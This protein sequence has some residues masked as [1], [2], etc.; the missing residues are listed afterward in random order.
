VAATSGPKNVVIV[1]DTSGSMRERHR[2]ALAITAV[3]T[4]LET[5]TISDSAAVIGFSSTATPVRHRRHCYCYCFFCHA[6]APAPAP[7]IF[8]CYMD[9]DTWLG[10]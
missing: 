2:M 7:G 9:S 5:F 10:Q 3:E 8:S 1:V 4:L 6:P